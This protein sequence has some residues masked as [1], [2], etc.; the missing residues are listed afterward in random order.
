[1]V[2]ALIDV[3]LLLGLLSLIFYILIA[4]QV[5]PSSLSGLSYT[6]LIIAIILFIVWIVLR[7]V[8]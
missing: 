3:A 6:L 4:V 2:F 5:F 7:F 8:I 1:M